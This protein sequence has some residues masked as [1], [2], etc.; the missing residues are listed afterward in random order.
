MVK[1]SDRKTVLAMSDS[2]Q[3][4]SGIARLA[5]YINRVILNNRTIGT[6]QAFTHRALWGLLGNVRIPKR[7]A[8]RN[9]GQVYD[10]RLWDP[11][12]EH[13]STYH[14]LYRLFT[15][16]GGDPPIVASM[17]SEHYANNNGANPSVRTFT[18]DGVGQAVGLGELAAQLAYL[19][20]RTLRLLFNRSTFGYFP[21]TG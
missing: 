13:R 19:P 17:L 14:R 11:S 12:W 8:I 15:R 1:F 9:S 7:S 2:T 20:I 16:L 5:E 10:S 18:I 4:S 21:S 6:S 3:G